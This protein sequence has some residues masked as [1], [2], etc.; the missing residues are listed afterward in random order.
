MTSTR[1]TALAAGLFYL[2]S[3]VSI[4]TLFLYNS[5]RGANY[6]VGA[7][8]DTRVFIGGTLEIIVALAGIGTAV[9]LYPVVKR[10]NEGVALG[11]VGARTLEAATIVA[12][13]VSLLSV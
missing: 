7:G 2:L 10:Q 1:K 6:I 5:V 3:F 4:P 11:F 13:V 8:P 9:A 12:G